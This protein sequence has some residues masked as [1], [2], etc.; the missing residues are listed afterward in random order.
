[1]HTSHK[2][3]YSVSLTPCLTKCEIKKFTIIE[4]HIVVLQV[5]TN[6]RNFVNTFTKF[7]HKQYEPPNIALYMR[8]M[9]HKNSSIC[10]FCPSDLETICQLIWHKNR[11]LESM[12][13][14]LPGPEI[15]RNKTVY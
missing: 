4:F 15:S 2:I 6:E 1:M 13:T 11:R 5:I 10:L 14:R 8:R 12:A 3:K 9:R 7:H